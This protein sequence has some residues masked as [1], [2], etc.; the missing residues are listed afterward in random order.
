MQVATVQ[1]FIKGA[2]SPPYSNY[3]Q[4]MHNKGIGTRYAM[5]PPQNLKN[6][7]WP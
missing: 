7:F 3:Q 4:C 5:A 2:R 1:V 6:E